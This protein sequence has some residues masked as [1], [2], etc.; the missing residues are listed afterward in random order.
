MAFTAAAEDTDD[1]YLD[2]PNAGSALGLL[3]EG[4]DVADV[5]RIEGTRKVEGLTLAPD[6]ESFLVVDDPDDR[7]L[8]SGLYALAMPAGWITR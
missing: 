5:V 6:G 2:G 4:G 1:P 8:A 7:A 3:D